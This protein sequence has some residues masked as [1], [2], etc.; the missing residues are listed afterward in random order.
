MLFFCEI[1]RTV[2]YPEAGDDDE[3]TLAPKCTNHTCSNYG[4]ECS[5]IPVREEPR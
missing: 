5:P 3:W 2:Y 1:C 4:H